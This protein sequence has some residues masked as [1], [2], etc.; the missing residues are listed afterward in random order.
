MGNGFFVKYGS[1][2]S[3]WFGFCM[4]MGGEGIL[5]RGGGFAH[6]VLCWLR[7]LSLLPGCGRGKFFKHVFFGLLVCEQLK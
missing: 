5:L 7:S 4:N 3:L 1:G 6:V 2:S